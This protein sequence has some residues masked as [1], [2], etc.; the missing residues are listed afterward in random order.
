[1][2]YEKNEN[3]IAGI[4][5]ALI[6]A[7]IG[8]GCIILFSQLGFIASVSGLILVFCTLGGYRFLGGQLSTKG[9]VVSILFVIITPYLADR[10]DWAILLVREMEKYGAEYSISFSEAFEMIPELLRD[11]TLDMGEYVSNL[12]SIYIF[13][14]IGAFGTLRDALKT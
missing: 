2:N 13:A 10:I 1:M 4:V 6:G 9:I 5:G 7:I 12:V 3:V 14:L 8:G 11:G